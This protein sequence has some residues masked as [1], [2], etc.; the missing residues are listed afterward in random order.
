[1][2]HIYSTEFKL[3]VV[4]TYL[5]S[6][7]GV[8][9][10]AR[11]FGLPS[12][13]YVTKWIQELK[14]EGLLSQEDIAKVK[15][16]SSIKPDSPIQSTAGMTPLEKQL[17]EEVLRLQAENDFLKKLDALEKESQRKK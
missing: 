16:K 15:A 9:R 6:P 11:E 14:K 13:N 17:S 8:R 4:K 1:M 3:H 12:K 10:T 7:Y 2:P 5:I